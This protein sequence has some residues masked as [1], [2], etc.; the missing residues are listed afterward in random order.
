MAREE[1]VSSIPRVEQKDLQDPTC[2]KLNNIFKIL[3]EQI[4]AT[5]G[6]TGSGFN[7]KGVIS[8]DAVKVKQSGPP[9]DGNELITKATADKLYGI[10]AIRDALLHGSLQGIPVAPFAPTSPTFSSGTI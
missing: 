9:S 8:A 5:Q 2:S 3:F 1:I 10:D 7:F 4:H 6:T